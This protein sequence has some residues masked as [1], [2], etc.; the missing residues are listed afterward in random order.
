MNARLTKKLKEQGKKRSGS[1]PRVRRD[2]LKKNPRCVV[3]GGNKKLEAH[4]ILP[5][6][7]HPEL[8]LDENNLITLC[9]NKKEGIFCHLFV[10]HLGSFRS[11]NVQVIQDAEGWRQKILTRPKGSQRDT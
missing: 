11:Y 1:W 6:H 2:F 8:E 3:C 9:E 7:S 4:H 5:F 10:G